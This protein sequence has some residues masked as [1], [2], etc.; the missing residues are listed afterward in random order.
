MQSFN[1]KVSA[2]QKLI[3]SLLELKLFKDP[4]IQRLISAYPAILPE[5]ASEA[6]REIMSEIWPKTDNNLFPVFEKFEYFLFASGKRGHFVHQF[7]VFLLG[8]SCISVLTKKSGKV[9]DIFHFEELDMV[10]ETWLITSTTHDFGY[11]M[12]VASTITGKLSILY[13][14]FDMLALADKFGSIALKN[15]IQKETELLNL[16]FSKKNKFLL[17]KL[18]ITEIVADSITNTL[19]IDKEQVTLLIHEFTENENHGYVGSLILCRLLLKRLITQHE[20]YDKLINS[21]NFKSLK[22]AL[23]AIALHALP[24]DKEDIVKE[25][26]FDKNPFA[27]LLFVIDNLQEWSRPIIDN[28]N[29]DWPIYNLRNF[30]SSNDNITLEYVLSHDNWSNATTQ[31]VMESHNKK[32]KLLDTLKKP[33][34][35]VGVSFNTIFKKVSGEKIDA[36]EIVF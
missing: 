34:T 9:K 27:F 7:E 13:K 15:L 21:S 14:D 26:S 22:F 6:I 31:L 33:S 3:A 12:Q 8:L 11:P 5:R 2:E 28:D 4:H 23:G 35:V 17:E 18:D 19:K 10:I 32:R 1:L 25:I 16:L 24:S 30:S 36:F 20:D 29:K